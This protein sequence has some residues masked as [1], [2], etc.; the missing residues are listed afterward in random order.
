M[1]DKI[2]YNGV[3]IFSG[4]S[5]TPFVSWGQENIEY[6]SRWGATTSLSL[7]GQI[8][9]RCDDYNDLI[10]KQ[11]KLLSGFSQDFHSLSIIEDNTTMYDKPYAIIRGINFEQSNYV[12]IIPFTI[13]IDLYDQ[14]YW[15]GY[16]GVLEPSDEIS[17]EEDENGILNISR[18]IS[19]KGFNTNSQ[20]LENAKSWVLSR[21]GFSNQILP[22]FI[23]NC[24]GI[25][26][27]LNEFSE[28]I[29]RLVGEYEVTENYFVDLQRSGYGLVRYT[30]DINSGYEDGLNNVSIQGDITACKNITVSGLRSIYFGLDLY[31]LAAQNYMEVANLIDLNSI[32]LTSGVTENAFAKKLEFNT[33]FNND[34]SPIVWV[35]YAVDIQR[36]E[37]ESFYNVSLSATI[38]SR[39]TL[40]DRYARVLNYYNN[41]LNGYYLA[42]TA[43]VASEYYNGT[44]LALTANSESTEYDQYQGVITYNASWTNKPSN[45]NS[46]A[47]LN[48]TINIIPSITQFLPIPSLYCNGTYFIF[49][50]GLTNRKEVSVNGS[51][52]KKRNFGIDSAISECENIINNI[53]DRFA[54]GNRLVL[55][56]D[57]LSTISPANN[58]VSFNVKWSSEGQKLNV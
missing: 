29:N 19:A 53:R 43:F 37:G 55:D 20:S 2:L 47:D 44:P 33:S 57:T 23:Q 50:L 45:F 7:I 13:D 22:F 3:D 21:T 38:N 16:Y 11:N 54:L 27:C 6:G 51:S 48:Y 36:G 30:V 32:Y 18:T 46:L 17:Y 8:T 14:D 24:Y 26:P 25:S 42:N 39:G 58:S 9:G 5:P 4:V 10:N 28:R 31:S 12:G 52:I 41:N 56:E 49:D 1:A 35:D 34:Q 15:S 40:S